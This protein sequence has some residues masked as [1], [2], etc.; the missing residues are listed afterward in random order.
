M[1]ALVLEEIKNLH[2]V[3]REMPVCDDDHNAD[4][5]L[6]KVNYCSVCRT[7]AKMWFQGQRDLVLPRVL[8][9]EI[10]GQK[11]DSKEQYVVWPARVCNKCSNCRNGVENLCSNLQ[12]MGFHRDGGFAQYVKVPKES[13]IR[14]P[15][16]VP[17]EIACMTELLSSAV[18]AVE[19]VG[20]QKDQNVLIFGGGPAGL[21]LGLACKF[22]GAI[23]FIV[24]K[25]HKKR[26][27]VQ[28]FC[29]SAD[30]HLSDD[31]IEK[32]GFFERFDV[33]INAAPYSDILSEGILRLN[34]GGKFC[35]FS[36]FI[37]NV[38]LPSDLLNEVHYR[39]LTIIGAYG[40]TKRQMV[41]AL[42]ILEAN[43]QSIGLLIDKIIGLE[44]VPLVL[45]EILQ[46]QAL[47][48]VVD[49]Q[50]GEVFGN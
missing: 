39:Q 21:M 10:C 45:P 9:H 37:K 46:G 36:G 1:K 32:E 50:K 35:L 30:I 15:E 7:D 13:L 2:L 14:V 26:G 11:L 8:G 42:K 49:L 33:V 23:P 17:A 43:T 6:L 12:I 47:K 34:V 4:E 48:Y 5:V 41:V 19:Q 3:D 38:N 44:S 25:D 20:L 27:R 28:P 16:T 22:F 29:K 24:E 31:E 40:S 18:N